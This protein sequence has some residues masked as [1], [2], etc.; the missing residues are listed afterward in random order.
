MCDFGCNNS[1]GSD[2]PEPAAIHQENIDKLCLRESTRF[3]R[4][5]TVAQKVFNFSVEGLFLLCFGSFYCF[6]N[7][8]TCTLIT[9]RVDVTNSMGPQFYE[10][11]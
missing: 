3:A 1:I 9:T 11:S 4:R 5:C 10:A 7:S 2:A 6:L 8:V